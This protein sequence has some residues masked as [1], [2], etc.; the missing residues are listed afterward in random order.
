M[1][2]VGVL[3][4]SSPA[5]LRAQTDSDEHERVASSVQVLREMTRAED[6][7]GIPEVLL[8]RARA[9]AVIPHVVRGAFI[10]GGRWGKG[11]LATR[12][13]QGEWGPASFLDLSGASV[14]FQIGGDATDLI[15][16]FIE[17]DGLEALLEDRVELGANVSAA[18]GPLGRSAE[19]GTNATLDSAIYAYSRS[20]G[21]FA[22]AALDGTVITIDDSANEKAFGRAI[23]GD[24]ALSGD[25]QTPDVF[26]PF[27]GVVRELTPTQAR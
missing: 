3:A 9:I 16:V 15:M 6:A 8:T 24:V 4:W 21:A 20:K 7:E 22:G 27:L 25:V 26:A 14:G 10:V 2:M 5:A 23:D 12:G 18:A 1:G 13:A 19:I 17:E 11:V